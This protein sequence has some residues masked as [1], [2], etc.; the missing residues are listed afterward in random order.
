LQQGWD[1]GVLSRLLIVLEVGVVMMMVMVMV[2]VV[3]DH[4]DLRLR[5]IG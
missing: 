1:N 4:Y 5:R 3:Y 2:V